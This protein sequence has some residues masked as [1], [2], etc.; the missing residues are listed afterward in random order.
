MPTVGAVTK[1]IVYPPPHDSEVRAEADRRR[2]L[3]PITPPLSV[4]RDGDA[5]VAAFE[6]HLMED[7]DAG[8]TGAAATQGMSMTPCSNDGD[9]AMGDHMRRRLAEN[10]S[11]FSNLVGS[12]SLGTSAAHGGL[13]P[14]MKQ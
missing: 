7:G 2:A 11:L 10:R 1:G 6:A 12:P 5:G 4:L 3:C 14:G 13:P 9:H 8:A